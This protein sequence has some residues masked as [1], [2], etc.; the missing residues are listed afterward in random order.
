MLFAS[1]SSYV[2]KDLSQ[3]AAWA[4]KNCFE[5]ANQ[6]A[7]CVVMVNNVIEILT[8]MTLNKNA[9]SQLFVPLHINIKIPSRSFS[10]AILMQ[11]ICYA[12]G[13]E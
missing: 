3:A 2:L 13:C 10:E 9:Q 1:L 12:F 5:K 11:E 8:L 7:L 4:L 6:C